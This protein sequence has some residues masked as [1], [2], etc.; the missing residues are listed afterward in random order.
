MSTLFA[1]NG[2]SRPSLKQFCGVF[3]HVLFPQESTV[4]RSKRHV[5]EGNTRRL[6]RESEDDKIPQRAFFASEEAYREP[7]RVGGDLSLWIESL[8]PHR[9]VRAQLTHT[10]PLR[11]PSQN[12]ANMI[13]QFIDVNLYSCFG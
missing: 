10:A 11:H 3:R 9:T 5:S 8:P 1:K 12:I 13:S 6:Q 4:L 7:G 2:F